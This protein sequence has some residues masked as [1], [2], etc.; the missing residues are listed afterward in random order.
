M[1]NMYEINMALIIVGLILI[2]YAIYTMDI[3]Y[4]YAGSTMLTLGC[5]LLL[6]SDSKEDVREYDRD[7]KPSIQATQATQATPPGENLTISAFM[8]Q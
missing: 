3:I 8:S 5:V 1:S 6:T 2:I 7:T 4:T